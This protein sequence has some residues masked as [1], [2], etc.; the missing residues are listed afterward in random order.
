LDGSKR[1]ALIT[2]NIRYPTGLSI[3]YNNAHR[4]YFVDT[5]LSKIESMKPN[6]QDRTVILQGDNLRHPISLDVFESSFYWVTRDSGDL[7]RQDKFGRGVPVLVDRNLVNP[8]SIVV[9]HEYKY[10]I[11]VNNPCKKSTCSH[12]CLIIPNGIRCSCP[13][14]SNLA[15]GSNYNC[16]AGKN[17]NIP[18]LK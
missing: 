14:G 3:D 13:E 10:N 15:I 18:K 16:E 7:I 8:T 11:S 6:G 5:K 9:A 2:T 4:V 17:K 12:L 1:W